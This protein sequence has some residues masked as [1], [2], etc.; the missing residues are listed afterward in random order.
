MNF[1]II[2]FYNLDEVNKARENEAV[3]IIK[4]RQKLHAR[5]DDQDDIEAGRDE[6]E[7][8]EE[9]VEEE[10]EERRDVASTGRRAARR[11]L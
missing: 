2:S 5:R 1:I 6:E 4:R 8:Y 11:Q 3:K 9:G 7:E 10:E